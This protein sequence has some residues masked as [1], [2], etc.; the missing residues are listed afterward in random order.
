MENSKFY[1]IVAQEDIH[2]SIPK[3]SHFSVGTS[4]Y[5]AH[6]HGLAIDIY[7]KVSLE[8][9]KVCSPVSG[10]IIEIK[11]QLAPKPK[12][13]GGIDKDFVILIENEDNPEIVYKLLHVN[14]QVQIGDYIKFGDD[15]GITIKNGYFAPWSSPH[16]HLEVRSSE[17]A[18]RARG[19][20][21]FSLKYSKNSREFKPKHNPKEP[22]K[23]IPV[24]IHSIYPE[25]ILVHFPDRMYHKISQFYGLRANISG[26][27]CILDGGIPQYN[28]GIIHLHKGLKF[29]PKIPIYFAK[30][31]IGFLKGSFNNFGFLEFIPLEIFIKK[32]EIKG[33][34]LF[35]AAFQ[36]LIKIIPSKKGQFS[37]KKNSIQKLTIF[38]KRV[39]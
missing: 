34:S 4:P 22:M 15:L 5:Y 37:F 11:R 7:H 30:R 25:F 28:N 3:E 14:P 18:V 12:F 38:S 32:E 29:E 1:E 13:P 9:Y 20:L 36:P 26:L 39:S 2:I 10:K 21:S 8:N 31:K 16:I 33:I 19:G 23:A 27:N 24:Q 6:Q 17:D 35:L